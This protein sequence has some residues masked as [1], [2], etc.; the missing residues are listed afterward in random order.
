MSRHHHGHTMHSM[1]LRLPR[2]RRHQHDLL[3][4]H[5]H[6]EGPSMLLVFAF[7][8]LALIIIA[9]FTTVDCAILRSCPD[10][11]KDAPRAF[12]P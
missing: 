9:G 12:N 1:R 10:I 8:G 11:V 2:R 6:W 5:V 7:L 3:P 4:E